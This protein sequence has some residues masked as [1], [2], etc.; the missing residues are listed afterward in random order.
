MYDKIG[1][2]LAFNNYAYL[3]INMD[4]TGMKITCQF[5]LQ[6][7]GTT[8][9]HDPPVL[10]GKTVKKILNSDPIPNECDLSSEVIDF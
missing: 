7:E 4:L 8:Y 3:Y 1:F 10:L 6:V 2:S 9:S 5:G